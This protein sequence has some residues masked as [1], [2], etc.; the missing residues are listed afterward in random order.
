MH[1]KGS[2]NQEERVPPK[3]SDFR[4]WEM[5][6][7]IEITEGALTFEAGAGARYTQI[8]PPQNVDPP[9]RVHNF[10][11][12]SGSSGSFE[13][14]LHFPKWASGEGLIPAQ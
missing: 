13:E 3:N 4:R 14:F 5:G 1:A 12:L 10:A 9:I 2:P 7:H 6:R 8:S 11:D